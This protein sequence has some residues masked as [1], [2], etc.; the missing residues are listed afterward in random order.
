MQQKILNTPTSFHGTMIN[1]I[2]LNDL[3]HLA[4]DPRIKFKHEII[5]NKI[6]TIVS[7]MIAEPS[8]WKL[9]YAKECRGITFN[10]QGF[11]IA[12]PFQK[13]FNINEQEETQMG[14][15][16]FTNAEL[17]DK[18]DGS[19]LTPVL[20][21][22]QVYWKTKKSFFSDVAI[23]ASKC[24]PDNIVIYAKKMLMM[25]YTPI[26]EFTHP[27]CRIV[28]DY[29]SEPTF[30]LL[31]VRHM[32]SGKYLP[33]ELLQI[34]S[35]T[36]HVPLIHRYDLEPI[37]AIHDVVS[38]KGIEGYVIHHKNGLMT[39]IK[40][41]WYQINHRIMTEIRERDIALAVIEESID[42]IKSTIVGMN[43]SIDP[44]LEIENRVFGQLK[45]MIQDT[46]SL[47]NLIQ[48][49]P[50]RKDAALKY[51][52]NPYFGLAISLVNG[53]EANYVNHWKKFH[54]KQDYSLR[55]VYNQNFGKD[56]A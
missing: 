45:Q 30:T 24:V 13:F 26:F 39:K 50:T 29:G 44:I 11:C 20:I 46:E 56:D 49:E 55:I 10:D 18:R 34:H 41:S 51:K 9:P 42:D 16:D 37:K 8:L 52:N 4:A 53:S 32:V 43:L 2:H 22:N 19:M 36:Y 33:Y 7:Y 40:S 27:D 5:D 31:A 54:L 21:K 28:I 6:L 23:L 3:Q 1:M 35:S 47:A 12:R 14:N 38:M 15:L 25:G 48:V 17:Y